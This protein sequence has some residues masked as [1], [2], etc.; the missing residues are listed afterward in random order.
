[1]LVAAQDPY[2]R[3]GAVVVVAVAVAA[4]QGSYS[5]K[6]LESLEE[7]A[8]L[9]A[10][11]VFAL[12]V[13]ASSAVVDLAEEVYAVVAVDGPVVVVVGLVVAAALDDFEAQ[14]PFLVECHLGKERRG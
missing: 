11:F 10:A 6:V 12:D 4:E 3:S 8:A 2:L 1:M 13:V 5:G 7:F 9:E 14:V